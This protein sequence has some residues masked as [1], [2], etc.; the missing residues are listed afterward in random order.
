V[1]QI[2]RLV[3]AF[4]PQRTRFDPSSV[5]G[6]F[7]VNKWVLEQVFSEYVS[8]PCQFLVQRLLHTYLTSGASTIGPIFADVPS[9]PG[10]A[11]PWK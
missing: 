8:F 11:P 9:G 6:G 7:I 4:L 1:P 5:D 2:R 3:A 10:L